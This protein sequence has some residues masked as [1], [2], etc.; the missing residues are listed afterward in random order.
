MTGPTGLPVEGSVALAGRGA[1]VG[2]R[3]PTT[4]V[5]GC[6]PLNVPSTRSDRRHM[7]SRLTSAALLS[8]AAVLVAAMAPLPGSALT[9]AEP[10]FPTVQTDGD[11]PPNPAPTDGRV[12]CEQAP[13]VFELLCTTY[14]LIVSDYVDEVDDRDLASA[15]AERVR[16]AGLAERT[17][18]EPPP[19]PLPTPE[20]EEVCAAID[21]VEDTAT[22]VEIAIRGMA[23]SLDPNSSYMTTSQYR[24]FRESLENK[25]TSGLGVAFALVEDGRPCSTVSS[26]CRPVI[27]EVYPGGPA[28]EA[29]LTVG[30]VLVRLG[31]EF[32]AMLGCQAVAGLDRFP[33]GED[34]AVT[35]QRGNE[36]VTSTIGAADLSIPVARG[37][38]V[39]GNIG[40]LRLDVFS[41]SA[42][43]AVAE[44]LTD[45]AGQGISGL[46]L[47]LRDNPGGYVSSAIGTAGIF[48]PNLSVIVHT[49]SR[50]ELETVRPRGKEQAPDPALLPMV[51]AVDRSSASASELVTGA[52]RDH[53]RAAVVGRT[54][55]G[56]GTGQSS[57]H[58]EQDGTLVGVL[59]LTT[60][61]WFTPD[62]GSVAG[63]IEPDTVLDLPPCLLP[64]EVA[65]QAISTVRPHITGLAISSRPSGGGSYAI[66]EAVNVTAAFSSPVVVS[67]GGGGP[68]VRIQVGQN[69]RLASYRSGTDTTEL[70][71]EY[72]VVDG[73]ADPD[74]ISIP[75]D[76]FLPGAGTIRMPA[77]LDALVANDPVAADSG[78]TVVTRAYA[79]AAPRT[80]FVD[81]R[82][83]VH[84]LNIARIADAGITVGC[85]PPDNDRYCPDQAV[86]RAQLATFLARAL[87][88]PEASRDHFGDDDGSIHEESI[89]RLAEVAITQ[90]CNPPDNDRYCPDQAVTR[91][92]LATF[93][94]RALDL[95][96][97]SE[98][99]VDLEDSPHRDSIERLVAAGITVGCNP[100][101][102]DRYCPDQAVTRAQLAT[103]LFR[104][105]TLIAEKE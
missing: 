102:N 68:A 84:G 104:A 97:G 78:Q 58:L 81:T 9:D 101:D 5:T 36:T 25:G 52:L 8:A 67:E 75:A 3:R 30:D 93:L 53:D 16:E 76:S 26:T 89:N 63:G 92:Q 86:T 7:R 51:V 35:V 105:L 44:V 70:V 10:R 29:G 60:I 56:K 64:A 49:V 19:C 79:Y 72:T 13:D 80:M 43:D 54:T 20:F 61:R 98:R 99:F 37:R 77:G 87:N 48:L 71:F 22:A 28:E 40:H 50:D 94:A 42:D 39:D 41:S 21:A 74:G 62:G 59:H 18:G 55:Y 14:R 82:N 15:A 47:D 6:L 27:S 38:V 45:L 85:N 24:S 1:I 11:R 23:R 34:V 83:T 88:L 100:P 66:G 17:G 65:R 46:V 57:Y 31:D 4:K 95:A 73:D 2:P 91:A 96:P 90:G 103:F 12:T 32:P 33:S 69:F